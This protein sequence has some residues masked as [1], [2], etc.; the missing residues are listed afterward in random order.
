M[1]GDVIKSC[2]LYSFQPELM[3][4]LV[5]MSQSVFISVLDYGDVIYG[6]ASHSTLKTLDAVYHS[7]L[8]FITETA[9]AHTTVL[10]ITRLASQPCLK[11]GMVI[12]RSLFT[13]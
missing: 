1:F 11:K 3:L 8:R 2:T 9:M 12:G 6:N 4:L 10:C 13:K 7:A 5:H